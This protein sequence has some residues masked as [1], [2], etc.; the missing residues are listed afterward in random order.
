MIAALVLAGVAGFEPTNDGVR[1][2]C[3]TAWRHPNIQFAPRRASTNTYCTT[4]RENYQAFLYRF[5]KIFSKKSQQAPFRSPT[6]QQSIRYEEALRYLNT[7]PN[8]DTNETDILLEELLREHGQFQDAKG[9]LEDMTYYPCAVYTLAKWLQEG[10]LGIPNYRAAYEYFRHAT[11]LID[12]P[13]WELAALQIAR[14]YRDGRYLKQD[15]KK[16]LAVISSLERKLK[17]SEDTT[18]PCWSALYHDLAIAAA[19]RV[20]TAQ[21]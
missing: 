11:L 7:H 10:K 12:H 20:D 8:Y 2:R 21:A 18:N 4:R 3:L 17:Q 13:F 16:Y 14:M 15:R 19:E 9:I 1:V 6:L 5:T